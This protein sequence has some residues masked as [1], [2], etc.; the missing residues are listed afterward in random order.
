[1]KSWLLNRIKNIKNV[2][3]KYFFFN[4][5]IKLCR[6]FPV[7]KTFFVFPSRSFL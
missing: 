3:L 6:L 5:L 2:N 7:V 1:M 4:G